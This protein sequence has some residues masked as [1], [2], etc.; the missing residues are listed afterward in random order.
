MVNVKTSYS[1]LGW[2]MLS[3]AYSA[4]PLEVVFQC[5]NCGEIIDTSTDRNWISTGITLT[6]LNEH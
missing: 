5:Q 4:K 3:L 1:K 2:L 6:S